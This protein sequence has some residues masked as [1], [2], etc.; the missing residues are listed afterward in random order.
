M[1]NLKNIKTYLVIFLFLL[2]VTSQVGAETILAQ[3]HNPSIRANAEVA[4]IPVI[5]S[6]NFM[7]NGGM[8]PLSERRY[9]EALQVE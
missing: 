8:T 9:P 1:R 4:D 7:F 2:S 6:E 5:K 3:L